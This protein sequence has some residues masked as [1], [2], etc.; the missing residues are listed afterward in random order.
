MIHLFVPDLE[1]GGG[2]NKNRAEG[3]KFLGI[4]YF[5]LKPPNSA[6][7]DFFYDFANKTL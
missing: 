5:S 3:A 4:F 2:F 7:G 6:A 1:Q